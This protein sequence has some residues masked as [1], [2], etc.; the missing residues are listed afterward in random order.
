MAE[1]TPSSS[2]LSATRPPVP[3]RAEE[4]APPL[5]SGSGFPPFHP[6]PVVGLGGSAGSLAPLQAFFSRIATDTGMAFVVVLHLAADRESQLAEV[7]QRQTPLPVVQ[8]RERVRV[9]PNRVYVIPPG[10]HLSMTDG[11]LE[12]AELPRERGRRVAVDYF[13]RTLADTHGASAVAIVLSGADSDGAI[14]IKRIKER[15][16]LTIAQAPEECEQPGMPTS[17]IETGHV[18]WVLRATDMAD[19]IGAYRRNGR[20]LHL[21]VPEAET[22]HARPNDPIGEADLRD[23]L[24]VL[25]ARTGRDFHTYKRGTIIRRV[26]RRMQFQGLENLAQYHA[27]LRTQPGE[28]AALLQDLLISVTNF[29][30]DRDAFDTLER[31]IPALFKGKGPRDALRVWVAGCATGEEA[32][33]LAMLLHEQAARLENPPPIQVFA[34]DIDEA[35]IAV[36]RNAFYPE[37]IVADVSDER[38]RKFFVRQGDGYRIGT[39]LRETVLFASH[40]LLA[41]AP[42]SR[43]D[44]VSCRNLLIYLNRE[45]QSRVFELFHFALRPDGLLF[46]GTSESADEAGE[47][48][49]AEHKRWRIYRRMAA[50]VSPLR[51]PAPVLLP[52]EPLPPRP[53]PLPEPRPAEPPPLPVASGQLSL[54]ELHFKL[55]E[56]FAPP[57]LVVNRANQIA[58]LSPSAGRFLK[59]A[60][61]E[62]TA[63]LLSIVHPMLRLELRAALFRAREQGVPVR[64][65][66]IP[67]DFETGSRRVDLAVHPAATLAPGYLLVTFSEHELS[68]TAIPPHPVV[69]T[70]G[71]VESLER[72]LEFTKGLLRS[73]Q[74]QHVAATEEMKASNE[75]LQAMNEEL[76]SASEELETS[77]EELQ[78]LNEELITVNQDL[79]SKVDELGRANGDL[80]NLMAA[81]NIATVFLDRELR[82]QRYT[83]SAVTLFNLIA[84]DVGRPLFD[85]S[86]RLEFDSVLSDVAQ[87]LQTAEPLEREVRAAN[88][89]WYLAGVVP[90]RDSDHHVVGVVLTFV[91][92]TPR[93]QAEEALVDSKHELERRVQARTTELHSA[94]VRLTAEIGERERAETE[95]EKM[96]QALLNAQEAERERISRELHDEIGQHVTALLLGLKS[97]EAPLAPQA[98]A[99]AILTS[100]QETAERIGGE[101]HQVAVELR[102]TSLRDLGL[103]RCLA[104]F[105]E[106]RLVFAKIAV[107]FDSEEFGAQRLPEPLEIALYRVI[108]EAL[109]NVFRHASATR[110]AVILR[111]QGDR[112]VAIVEDNGIG[113]D[114]S[115]EMAKV[116]RLPLGLIGMRERVALVG[117]EITIESNPGA[118]TT[119]IVRLPTTFPVHD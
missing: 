117:G 115:S 109:Q 28:T 31:S 86:H 46:L 60:G 21:P 44:L 19:R 92:I 63:D 54:A 29:F 110:V 85:L 56:H 11:H 58:H 81:T 101:I 108:C 4:N 80:Q 50:R 5:E 43:I 69:A 68:A 87:V 62:P 106:D 66:D 9:E 61:G 91:D 55:V 22:A 113:F 6:L 26:A 16:G 32:Y 119:V 105:I 79:K 93:K 34:T 1:A 53:A 67:V 95:R 8:V 39:T 10:H 30:R 7:L 73:S 103:V 102:P 47:L 13:F 97:L 17:A 99:R 23:V 89:R 70:E 71:L 51:T 3:D 90:Y 36:A 45:A 88:C 77:R 37:A 118:G 116:P 2:D 114:V 65:A 40:D 75:E 42:F 25:R 14:G 49:A 107:D 94:N 59:F 83:P 48:F 100:L 38:L 33:S 52:P 41:D 12:L 82:V 112:I 35:A 74:E 78:S 57:S 111:R 98:E 64:T 20:R 84:T 96:M 27:F 24:S 72:E 15:G 76:R 18:D 104:N